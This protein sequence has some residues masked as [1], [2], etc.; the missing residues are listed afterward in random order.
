MTARRDADYR[1]SVPTTARLARCTDNRCQV[2]TEIDGRC[3]VGPSNRVDP[4]EVDC[5][6]SD[7][8]L[9]AYLDAPGP[10]VVCSL[11][12]ARTRSPV[13]RRLLNL[14]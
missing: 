2:V 4:P 3:Y 7:F 9:V 8:E 13:A 11:S 10:V 5:G 1:K 12:L 14:A 6:L